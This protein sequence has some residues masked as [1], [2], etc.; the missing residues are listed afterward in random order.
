MQLCVKNAFILM[1]TND[2]S[3]LKNKIRDWNT[4]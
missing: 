1:N 4:A 3:M 2:K